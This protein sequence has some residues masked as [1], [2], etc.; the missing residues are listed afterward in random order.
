MQHEIKYFFFHSE[1]IVHLFECFEIV[2][3]PKYNSIKNFYKVEI[4]KKS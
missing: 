1:M 4:K 2:F 3:N